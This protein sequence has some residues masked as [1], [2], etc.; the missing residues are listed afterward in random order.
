MN[1]ITGKVIRVIHHG[2]T[3]AG[4]PMLSVVLDTDDRTE[5]HRISDNEAL[6]FEIENPEYR[7]TSHVFALTRAG[8]ISHVVQGGLWKKSIPSTRIQPGDLAYHK[9]RDLDPRPVHA[10]DQ[11]SRLMTLDIMGHITEP[12]AISDYTFTRREA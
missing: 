2:T 5:S 7:E 3:S 9:H 10:V 6:S 1:Y 8:R 4:G 11:G 12:V